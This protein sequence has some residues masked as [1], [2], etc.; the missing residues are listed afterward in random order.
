MKVSSLFRYFRPELELR[1]FKKW[2]FEFEEFGC[3]LDKLG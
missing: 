1:I 2:E 3:L